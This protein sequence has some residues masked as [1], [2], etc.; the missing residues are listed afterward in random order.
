M[1]YINVL[2]WLFSYCLVLLIFSHLVLS[3]GMLGNFDWKLDGVYKKLK[4]PCMISSFSGVGSLHLPGKIGWG[5]IPFI[6][7]GSEPP[8]VGCGCGKAPLTS[9]LPGLL[10]SSPVGV[11]RTWD[12]HH[13]VS[14]TSVFVSLAH[15]MGEL[16]SAL[17]RLSVWCLSLLTFA[18]V[19]FYKSL[20]GKTGSILFTRV[21]A[22]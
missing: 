21:L 13:S 14:W 11:L 8:K 7:S 1:C 16:C 17:Q 2:L 15:G 19:G 22:H 18:A 5:L 6:L 4:Q 20:K 12:V 10:R 9:G 3:L